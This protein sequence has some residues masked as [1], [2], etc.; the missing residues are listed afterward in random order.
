MIQMTQETNT[1]VRRETQ[2][3]KI[4]VKLELYGKGLSKIDTGVAFLDH[5]LTT[6]S[7]HSN[8]DLEVECVGDTRIDDHHSVEDIGI[9]LGQA[10]HKVLYPIYGIERFGNATVL[11]DDASV[12]CDIDLS[13]RAY[14][15]F[16]LPIDGKVG[17][18]DV[19]LVEEF[20]KG[21][22]FNMPLNLHLITNRG[23]NKHHLIEAAFKAL[24]ISMRRAII[25]NNYG[26]PSTKGVL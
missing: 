19:E 13:N 1:E 2:E 12:S 14:F 6:F 3:T 7:K 8:I 5:M 11:M 17:N 4:R 20:F 23:H 21:F 16:E 10:F 25:R 9:T 22:T 24:A 15:V 26:I 18:F